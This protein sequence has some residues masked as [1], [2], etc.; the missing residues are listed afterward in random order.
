MSTELSLQEL[1]DRIAWAPTYAPEGRKAKDADI[2]LLRKRLGEAV[3]RELPP[4]LK[5]PDAVAE[6]ERITGIL[7]YSGLMSW[8]AIEEICY[9]RG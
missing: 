6:F 8:F 3:C 4:L 5:R 9:A 2:R 1:F 7:S